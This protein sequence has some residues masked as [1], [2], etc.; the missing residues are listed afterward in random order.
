MPLQ[1]LQDLKN[2]SKAIQTELSDLNPS[3]LITLFE[4]DLTDMAKSENISEAS[5]NDQSYQT[6]FRFHNQ[7]KI[8]HGSSITWSGKT[9]LPKIYTAA[10]IQAVGFEYNAKGTLPTPKL[11]ITVNEENISYLN[12]FKQRILQYGDLCG[13]KVV[14]IRTFLR[15]LDAENFKNGNSEADWTK[16]FPRDIFYID[17]KT[18]ENK[19]AMEFELASILDVEGLMLPQRLVLSKCFFQYRGCGC[20]YE[21]GANKT[22]I[23]EDGNLPPEAPPIA[24]NTDELIQKILDVPNLTNMGKYVSDK[25]YNKGE[26]CYIEKD[27]VKYYYVSKTNSNKIEPPDSRY[28]IEDACGKQVKSC[29]IRWQSFNLDLLKH[30]APQRG[31]L[32]KNVLPYGGFP[33]VSKYG[34]SLY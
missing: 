4:I 15:Y 13:A 17:R 27:L 28:W 30:E 12:I 8:F 6:V 2:S 16:E 29:K 9:G 19:F 23:H 20:C 11:S 26:F 32:P 1:T 14:R 22:S 5:I 10:P 24:T 3:T 33:S 25:T 7:V 18:T 34:F 31:S 21:Y